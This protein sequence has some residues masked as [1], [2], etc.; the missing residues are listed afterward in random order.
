MVMIKHIV[1]TFVADV[2]GHK[3]ITNKRECVNKIHIFLVS[4]YHYIHTHVYW[5][6]CDLFGA[7]TSNEKKFKNR[8]MTKYAFESK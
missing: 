7:Y 1:C 2:T 4:Q 8:W 6:L 5:F 3:N